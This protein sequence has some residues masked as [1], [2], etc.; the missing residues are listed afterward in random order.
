[1]PSLQVPA[2]GKVNLV[3]E[4]LRRRPDGYHAI[5]TVMHALEL[6]DTLTFSAGRPGIRVTCDRPGV[7]ED[8]ENLVGRAARLLATAT[9]RRPAVKIHIR[10]RVPV[11]AGMGGGSSDAAAALNGLCRFWGLRRDPKLLQDLAARLGSDVAFF[12]RG[13]CALGTGRGERIFPWPAV[14]GLWVALVNP[15]VAVSTAEVYKKLNLQL[16]TP[17]NYINLMRPAIIQK[18]PVKIGQKL[19]NQLESVT[20]A[21]HPVVTRI[22]AEL[23]A[24]GALAAMMTGSGPTVFA[25]LPSR[26]V[27]ALVLRRLRPKYPVVALT[28]TR[29]PWT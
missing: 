15:G 7:P 22:K 29:G 14:P 1:M 9:G 21:S 28:R 23:L 11:A 4:V 20:A 6:A 8:E 2:P 5:R 19:F 12:L 26:E 24:C 25:L 10:K 3:L 13:G 17:M 18:N 27:G 16:T